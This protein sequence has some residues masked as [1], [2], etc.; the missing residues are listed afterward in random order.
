MYLNSSLFQLNNMVTRKNVF[1][2]D[3]EIN[4]VLKTPWMEYF[5][6]ETILKFSFSLHRYQKVFILLFSWTIQYLF[7]VALVFILIW[8]TYFFSYIFFSLIWLQ[9]ATGMKKN[10]PLGINNVFWLIDWYVFWNK[11]YTKL[12]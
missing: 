11:H 8:C 2:W 10:F 6:R 4:C 3:H 7:S 12:W 5:M 1:S 9:G